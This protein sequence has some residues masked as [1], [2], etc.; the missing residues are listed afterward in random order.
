[1]RMYASP[2]PGPALTLDPRAKLWLLLLANAML[3]LHVRPVTQAIMVA[4]FLVPPLMA[5]RW[6][7]ALRFAALYAALT[8]VSM[9]APASSEHPVATF[10]AMLATGMA[11]M[12]PCLITGAYAFATTSPGAFVC[13]MRRLHVPEAVI[14]PCVVI[15]RF[16]P[17]IRE[18]CHHIRNAMALRG[19][20]SDG[21]ALLRRP[22]R[23]LEY[24][25]MPLLMN[26][27]TV[28]HDLSVAA[29]TKGVGRPGAHTSRM[30][31]R[32]CA[33]DW[34][35]IAVCTM[36]LVLDVAGVLR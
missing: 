8:A 31:I 26:A 2:D 6:R 16:F 22:A 7:M 25:L 12:L 30:E 17:T 9:F 18:D 29:L 35:V 21:L 19:I 14:I 20:A 27:T 23:S 10:V 13:A 24:I 4:L 1:M 5:G 33:V 3:F 15:I 11:M 28:A 36:P 34:A 32:M